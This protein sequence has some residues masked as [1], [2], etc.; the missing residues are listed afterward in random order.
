[1]VKWVLGATGVAALS[2]V[3]IAKYFFNRTM[4]RQNAKVERTMKMSG[5]DWGAYKSTMD[6]NKEWLLSLPKDTVTLKSRDNLK[7]RGYYFQNQNTK[8]DKNQK[9]VMLFHGYTSNSLGEHPTIAR[10]YYDLG[11][12]IFMMDHRAHGDSEGS[13]IGFGVLDRL[14]GLAWI[15][16]LNKRFKDNLHKIVLHGDSMG[17]ATVTMMSGLD[18][19]KNVVAIVSDCAFT[20]AWDVFDHVLKTMYHIP[21]YPI[22]AIADK[23]VQKQAGYSIRECNGLN[24]VR[25]AK[26]PILFLHGENDFFVPCKM[27]YQLYENCASEKELFV[28]KGASHANSIYHGYENYRDKVTKFLEK[29]EN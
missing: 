26:V 22:L 28:I 13:Y 8:N 27:V 4:I 14:D 29:L 10:I 25:K 18:L 16:Y 6:T 23:M 15:K 11:Y 17:G 12:N 9:T 19:P 2:T 24:E 5:V 1:M 20:S 3:V 21:S 7:L